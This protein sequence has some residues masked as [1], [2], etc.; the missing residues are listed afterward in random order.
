LEKPVKQDPSKEKVGEEKQPSDQLRFNEIRE[1]MLKGP[2]AEEEID[3]RRREAYIERPTQ[4]LLRNLLEGGK[5]AEI[6]PIYDLSLGFRYKTVESVFDETVPPGK[7]E[8]FLEHLNHLEILKK[9]FFDT[10]S[11]CPVCGS[12]SITLH[13]RSSKCHSRHIVKTGLTEHIPCGN[14][15]E[16]DKYIQGHSM[17]SCPKC[18]VG[19]VEGEYRDMGLWYVCRE[20]RE[21]FE[22]PHLEMTCRKCEKQFTVET[23]IVR[24][25]PKY[26]LN[27]VREQEIR[28]NVT[29]LESIYKLLTALDFN[30]EMPASVIG[31]K[32][33]I[34]HKFSLLAKKRLGDRERIIAIDH[35]VGDVEVGSPP[36]ILYIYK[37]SEVKVDLPV[38]V[39][40]P[41]L[42]ETAKRIAQGYDLLVIEGIPKETERLTALNDEIQK[43][44]DE[45]IRMQ[46]VE[47]AHQWIF[48][49]GKRVDVWRDISGK[50]VGKKRK[51]AYGTKINL[52]K[53]PLEEKATETKPQKPTLMERIR[54]AIKKETDDGGND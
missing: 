49:K 42:S 31:E 37:I 28:Q 54:K 3:L 24:E 30:V 50:F 26:Y 18:G 5:K 23:A 36:L 33:G 7:A 41:R 2:E 17:P 38:F 43:R 51:N 11:A 16:R 22:R 8:G 46:A 9:S 4:K 53:L 47:V 15:D 21:R 45:R 27:P 20:C 13:Y 52:E 6:L 34:Q 35:A 12:T 29:S 40:I 48:R 19:L 10:I 39:A 1:L 44:L 14:I 25:I 32:S